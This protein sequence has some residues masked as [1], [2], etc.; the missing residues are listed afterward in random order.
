M[1]ERESVSQDKIG[2]H[3]AS[4]I[5]DRNYLNKNPFLFKI[6]SQFIFKRGVF[7]KTTV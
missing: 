2:L 4:V 3:A 7:F 5:K 1:R 6:S